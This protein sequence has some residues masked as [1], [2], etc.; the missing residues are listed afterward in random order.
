MKIREKVQRVACVEYYALKHVECNFSLYLLIY[1]LV[2]FIFNLLERIAF[3]KI[4][5]IS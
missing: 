1:A 4:A 3:N 5:G 2:E